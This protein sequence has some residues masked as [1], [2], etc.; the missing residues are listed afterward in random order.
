MEEGAWIRAG[1]GQHKGSRFPAQVRLQ[2]QGTVKRLAVRKRDGIKAGPM[3]AVQ[4]EE[5]QGTQRHQGTVEKAPAVWNR[6][7]KGMVMPKPREVSAAP[8]TLVGVTGAEGQGG[9]L[10]HCTRQTEAECLERMLFGAPEKDMQGMKDQI[11]VGSTVF[12]YNTSTRAVMGP[13]T[14]TS[15]PGLWLEKDAWKASDRKFAA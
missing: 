15:E 4:V 9:Y 12:L 10:F 11:K 13:Y 1:K 2:A 7:V 6:K 3:T 5:Q 14:A 8:D